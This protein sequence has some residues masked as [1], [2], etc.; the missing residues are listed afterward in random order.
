M[1]VKFKTNHE[2]TMLDHQYSLTILKNRRLKTFEMPITFLLTHYLC[3]V[4][5]VLI[6]ILIFEAPKIS[7]NVV[8]R[9]ILQIKSSEEKGDNKKAK[10]KHRVFTH[11]RKAFLKNQL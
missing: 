1:K 6:Y 7:Y 2:E 8:K 9:L 3:R 10:L 4:D 11:E 5:L